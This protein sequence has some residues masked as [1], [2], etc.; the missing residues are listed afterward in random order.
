MAK[1]T[2][3]DRAGL[4]KAIERNTYELLDAAGVILQATMKQQLSSRGTGIHWPFMRYQSSAPGKSPAVQTGTL[5]RSVQID[6]SRNKGKRPRIDVGSNL[7]YGFYLEY[8][9]RARVLTKRQVAFL[10]KRA[11]DRGRPWI[12]TGTG[13]RGI[14]PRPWA[15]PAA[16]KAL[17]KIRKLFTVD[18]LTKGYRFK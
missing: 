6:R 4:K 9:T 1:R 3:I 7:K 2:R 16:A 13:G 14:R 10:A 11:R 12:P 18:R 5:R 15:R 8:G 17:P